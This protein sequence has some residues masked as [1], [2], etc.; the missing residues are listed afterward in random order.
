MVTL[1]RLPV[2]S[3]LL[4]DIGGKVFFYEHPAPADPGR[5]NQPGGGALPEG[6][7]MQL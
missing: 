2:I 4:A 3:I 6:G 7:G 5:G 1:Q